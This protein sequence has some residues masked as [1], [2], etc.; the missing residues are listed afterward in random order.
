MFEGKEKCSTSTWHDYSYIPYF[1]YY[2]TEARN[3]LRKK[4]V[5]NVMDVE[6]CGDKEEIA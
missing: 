5:E 1:C 6:Q 4:V 3:Q 2:S